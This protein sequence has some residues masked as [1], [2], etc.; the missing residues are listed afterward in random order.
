[1]LVLVPGQRALLREGLITLITGKLALGLGLL[2]TQHRTAEALQH[3]RHL[4]P[5]AGVRRVV[6][7]IVVLAVPA[8]GPRSPFRVGAQRRHAA[9][10]QLG[11]AGE[12]GGAEL[13]Q[14]V[15]GYQAHA[16]E[17]QLARKGFV[18]NYIAF[19]RGFIE[20]DGTLFHL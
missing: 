16:R 12:V 9:A 5:F 20:Q 18:S 4:A 10:D 6:L 2:P 13:H 3:Q 19:C 8:V 14:L 11:E 15:H 7:R 1:M 17:G